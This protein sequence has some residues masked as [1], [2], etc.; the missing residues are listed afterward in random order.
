MSKGTVQIENPLNQSGLAFPLLES[1]HLLGIVCALGPAALMNL[2]LLGVGTHRSPAR[3]WRET[4]PLALGG[5]T[6]AITSRLL[7]FTIAVPEYSASTMF[8][9]KMVALT[10]AIVFYF[11]AVRSA[12][13]RERKASIVAVIS[14]TLYALVP[15]GG[16]LLGYD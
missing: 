13:A 7:L 16:I 3:I 2:R 10:A 4:L 15:L 1:I 6:I 9:I 11:T 5:L 14:L 8:R 12:A